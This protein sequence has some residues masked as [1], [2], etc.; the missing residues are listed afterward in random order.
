MNKPQITPRF[1]LFHFIDEPNV[2]T[3]LGQSVN[4]ELLALG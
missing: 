3:K 4:A 1:K 2:Y